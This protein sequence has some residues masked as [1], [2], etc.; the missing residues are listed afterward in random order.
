MKR[1]WLDPKSKE[2][3]D[4]AKYFK[5]DPGDAKKLLEAAGA[6]GMEVTFQ[7]P[8]SIYGAVFDSAAQAAIQYMNQIG[9][10]TTTD[11]QNYQSK[12]ITQTFSGNFSGIAFGYETPFPEGGSYPLRF[13]TDNPLNHEQV[14]DQELI[15][16]ANK[17]QA[18]LDPD[19]RKQ[20]FYEIQQKN[21]E[22]MYYVPAQA[23]AGPAWAAYAPRVHGPVHISTVP[24]SYGGATEV[25]PYWWIDESS[26]AT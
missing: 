8:A 17:Q 6:A 26:P 10:K 19:K 15:D 2:Q 23:G 5:F 16:L 18:E 7:Y 4:S 25:L 14:K 13:F 12:Y 22:K 20:I 9:I 21:A 11:V 24:G 1:W 3:G